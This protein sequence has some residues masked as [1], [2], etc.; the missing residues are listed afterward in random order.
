MEII[1]ARTA[2]FIYSPA[3]NSP[4]Y[5]YIYRVYV[6]RLPI[7][8]RLRVHVSRGVKENKITTRKTQFT[9]ATVN[10]KRF[11]ETTRIYVRRARRKAISEISPLALSRSLWKTIWY[12]SREYPATESP[13][14][15]IRSLSKQIHTLR[16]EG[17]CYSVCSLF[18]APRSLSR[19]S[20]SS[21]LRDTPST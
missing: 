12:S 19:R 4:S 17:N 20:Q 3:W 10:I 13:R 7:H 18:P 16:N 5:M 15:K 21:G 9:R 1:F 14:G 8:A 2:N 11:C 6:S